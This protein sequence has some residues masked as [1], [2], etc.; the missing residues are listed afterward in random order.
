MGLGDRLSEGLEQMELGTAPWPQA[1]KVKGALV[2]LDWVLWEE[3]SKG[4]R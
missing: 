4:R 3:Q 2:S 1:W